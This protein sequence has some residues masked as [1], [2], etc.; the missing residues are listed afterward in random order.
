MN[1]VLVVDKPTGMTS[2]DVVMRARR[3]LRTR[4]IG[5]AGTLDP[6]ATGVLVLAIGEATKLVPFLTAADKRYDAT[7]VLGT[8]TDTLDAEGTVVGE[9]SA[10]PALTR[11]AVEVAAHRFLGVIEQR[12]P[13]VSAIKVNGRALHERVRRGEDVAPPIRTVELHSFE[14]IAIE[15]D[16]IRFRLHSGK[17][18]YVR[19]FGRDLAEAL[20][21]VGHLGA[22]RRTASGAFDLA[23]AVS[24]ATIERALRDDGALE[25][26]RTSCL[27]LE[28]AALACLPRV[29]LGEGATADALHGRPIPLASL[30]R[31][32]PD[33]PPDGTFALFDPEGRLVA[34]ARQDASALRVARG[35]R[36]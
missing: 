2:H 8:E 34:L 27:S 19:S 24:F 25:T 11:D 17:G 23:K 14:L 21:T 32:L 20:G 5:H 28:D 6:M 1:G 18:F 31:P 4:A 26:L 12:A 35:I 7:L 30:N 3:A 22:L 16:R 15:P 36:S 9:P 13:C 29:D 33:A 10:P